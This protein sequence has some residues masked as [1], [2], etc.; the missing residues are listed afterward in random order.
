M[1]NRVD[2]LQAYTFVMDMHMKEPPWGIF[3]I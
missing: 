1:M 2:N 3:D